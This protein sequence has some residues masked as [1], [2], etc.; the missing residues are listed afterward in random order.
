MLVDYKD[1]Q[2][3][4]A[5][6]DAEIQALKME[7][8]A[9]KKGGLVKFNVYSD[10]QENGEFKHYIV[11]GDGKPCDASYNDMFEC[12][13]EEEAFRIRS[14]LTRNINNAV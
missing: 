8:E 11:F 9:K 12:S 5:K 14:I 6:K 10:Q 2:E 13:N 7:L 1:A 3:D 4:F